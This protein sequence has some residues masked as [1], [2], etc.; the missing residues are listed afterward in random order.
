MLSLTHTCPPVCQPSFGTGPILLP[1]TKLSHHTEQLQN[2]NATVGTTELKD[3]KFLRNTGN[4]LFNSICPLVLA[5]KRISR[6]LATACPNI[7]HLASG[8]FGMENV[9][10]A[11]AA[12]CPKSCSFELVDNFFAGNGTQVSVVQWLLVCFC[13]TPSIAGLPS[14][15]PFFVRICAQS[16]AHLLSGSNWLALTPS[17]EEL[18]C[19][20]P[21]QSPPALRHN[22]SNFRA[23]Q[24]L[25]P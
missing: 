3:V 18:H 21:S 22:D 13:H 4:G 10:E 1:D 5:V 9:L 11:F 17:L 6:L 14:L 24:H 7:T 25:H 15:F 19:N 12:L 23:L 20:D 2:F 8:V 16:A